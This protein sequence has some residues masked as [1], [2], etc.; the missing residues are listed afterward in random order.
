MMALA[1]GLIALA[2]ATPLF[3]DTPKAEIVCL[4]IDHVD[5]TSVI[6]GRTILFYVKGGKVW[7]NTLPRECPSLKFE[8]AFSQEITAGKICSNKQMIRVLRTGTRCSLGEFTPYT[9][10]PKMP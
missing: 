2:C 9:P 5:H 3:A 7:K 10:P 6:D 1:T 8:R 4:D